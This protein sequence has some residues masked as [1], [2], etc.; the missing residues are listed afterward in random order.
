MSFLEKI[1][2]AMG[3]TPFVS[4]TDRGIIEA[5]IEIGADTTEIAA[6]FSYA[7]ETIELVR[8]TQSLSPF[9]IPPS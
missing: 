2:G 1:V 3:G 5:M 4:E 6:T 8:S 9:R 7:P